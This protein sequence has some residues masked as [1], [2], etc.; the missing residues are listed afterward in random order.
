[1]NTTH[2]WWILVPLFIAV[3]IHLFL[4]S[5][6]RKKLL[7]RFANSNHL[8]FKP[9]LQ[10]KLQNILDISFHLKQD[11]LSRSFDQLSSIIFDDSIWVFRSVELLDL[12]AYGQS[13]SP[14][15]PRVIALFEVPQSLEEFFLLD[16]SMNITTRLPGSTVPTSKVTGLV[17]ECFIQ[18]N[19]LPHPLSISFSKGHGLIYFEPLVVGGETLSDI[20]SLY[21]I[22]NDFFEKLKNEV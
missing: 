20:N 17:K 22:A 10:A 7:E 18:D 19:Q 11:G 4:Y 16:K 13:Y 1:M 14:H 12:N 2:V 5:R 21:R 8:S 15:S 3:G 9:E 6:R